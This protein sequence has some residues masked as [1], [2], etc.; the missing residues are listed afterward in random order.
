MEIGMVE[1]SVKYAVV[2][3]GH[4]GVSCA[5]YLMHKN[6]SFFI[7]D[8]RHNPPGLSEIATTYPH[9]LITTGAIEVSVLIKAQYLIVS[10]G[11]PLSTPAIQ[12]AITH[13]VKLISDIDLFF[14]HVR[15]PVVGITGTNGKS[16]VTTL[17]G[18]MAQQAGI[19]SV[20]AGNIGVPVLDVLKTFQKDLYILELSSFQLERV[21]HCPLDVAALLNLSPDHLDAHGSFSAYIKAKQRIFAQCK[22]AVYWQDDTLTKPVGLPSSQCAAFTSRP[23]QQEQFGVIKDSHGY[24]VAQDNRVLLYMNEIKL[25]GRHNLTNIAAALTIGSLLQLPLDI[26]LEAVRS[27]SGLAHRCQW[28]DCIRGV[29]W[30]NDSKGTNEASSCSAIAGLAS[31]GSKNL[32]LIAGGAGKGTDFQQLA[33][34]IQR[35]VRAVILF[36]RDA[37]KIAKA[38]DSRVLVCNADNLQEAVEQASAVAQPGERVLL[39]PAC[40]SWDMFADYQ[41]RGNAFIK[42][43]NQLK[44]MYQ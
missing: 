40:T 30:F 36:G 22:S 1:F 4:T 21:S 20:V 37:D 9:I 16:T 13:G 3:L 2:G 35:Y 24:G 31:P 12:E 33:D 14:Q 38:I 8:S 39:S 29:D 15:A 10:P 34:N 28:V 26:M 23:P 18:A 42:H 27:F 5:H 7:V 11:I 17:V 6:Q 19:N 25:T 44:L 43:V 41:E 32:I